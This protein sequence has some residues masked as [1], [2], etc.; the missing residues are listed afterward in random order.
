MDKAAIRVAGCTYIFLWLLIVALIV[1][2]DIIDSKEKSVNTPLVIISVFN[3][4]CFTFV[5]APNSAVQISP[6]SL[7]QKM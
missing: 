3:L 7:S 6:T 1:I 4:E 5:V 2:R